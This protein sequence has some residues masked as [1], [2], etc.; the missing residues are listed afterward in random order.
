MSWVAQ[1]EDMGGEEVNKN[2]DERGFSVKYIHRIH[3]APMTS[4]LDRTAIWSHQ[5]NTIF[6]NFFTKSRIAVEE[7]RVA[8]WPF[9]FSSRHSPTTLDAAG[10]LASC[11]TRHCLHESAPL[12][13]TVNP[14]AL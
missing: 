4:K 2:F 14:Q 1:N 8:T 9:L 10:P 12:M 11:G 13:S 5:Q 7:T 6:Q 3:G